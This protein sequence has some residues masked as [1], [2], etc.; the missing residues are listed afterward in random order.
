MEKKEDTYWGVYKLCVYNR[1]PG[2]LKEKLD[3]DLKSE[4]PVNR[5][6]FIDK[7]KAKCAGIEARER[8]A[9]DRE[10][11]RCSYNFTERVVVKKC[12]IE[13]RPIIVPAE[14]WEGAKYFGSKLPNV[15]DRSW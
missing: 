15:A 5:E 8:I 7:E 6:I 13:G 11:S 1:S 9:H 4:F 10:L 14:E 2:T 12:T 3:R